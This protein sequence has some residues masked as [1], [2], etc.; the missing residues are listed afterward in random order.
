MKSSWYCA[1]VPLLILQ[2]A[3]LDTRG[4]AK[5]GNTPC[6]WIGQQI[7]TLRRFSQPFVIQVVKARITTQKLV[8][9]VSWIRAFLSP[10]HFASWLFPFSVS[11]SHPHKIL[12]PNRKDRSSVLKLSDIKTA[13]RNGYALQISIFH[14]ISHCLMICI[15]FFL[16]LIKIPNVSYEIWT[17]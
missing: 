1:T 3:T 12:E 17:C 8:F 5:N 11:V 10:L 14:C 16:N 4:A 9:W 2:A 7:K 6:C 15:N 13:A